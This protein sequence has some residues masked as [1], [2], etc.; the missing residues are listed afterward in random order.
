MRPMS[1]Q[2]E[3]YEQMAELSSRMVTAARG[4]DWEG[5]LALECQVAVLGRLLVAEET[6]SW[7]TSADASRK[8]VLI[9]RILDDDAEIRRHTEPWMERIRAYLG[10]DRRPT[11]IPSCGSA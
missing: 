7:P 1:S 6:G 10:S 5:L 4:E 9:Q 8:S 2:L 11:A 3:V